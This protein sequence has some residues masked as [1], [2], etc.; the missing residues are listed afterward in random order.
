MRDIRT[1]RSVQ[2]IAVFLNTSTVQHRHSLRVTRTTV[3][4]LVRRGCTP[5]MPIIPTIRGSQWATTSQLIHICCITRQ[6]SHCALVRRSWIVT[7]HP[8]STLRVCVDQ[9]YTQAPSRHTISTTLKWCICF[10]TS[11]EFFLSASVAWEHPLRLEHFST[12]ITSTLTANEL[13]KWNLLTCANATRSTITNS[14]LA[15][16]E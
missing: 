14:E 2:W 7:R 13:P 15:V 9:R 4:A 16:K 11:P 5:N 10:R 12:V 8:Y 1:N 6:Q 3:L